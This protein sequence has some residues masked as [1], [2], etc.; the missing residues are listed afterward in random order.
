M[1]LPEKEE[2]VHPIY[3]EKN[4]LKKAARMEEMADVVDTLF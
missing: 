3:T 2:R 4:L 1:F